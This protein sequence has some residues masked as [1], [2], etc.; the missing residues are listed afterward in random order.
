MPRIGRA[1][2]TS[3]TPE[4]VGPQIGLDSDAQLSLRPAS[5][6]IIIT[7]LRSGSMKTETRVTES[8]DR[9]GTA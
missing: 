7:F 6:A 8:V 3:S 4:M 5:T 2:L 9:V 1:R